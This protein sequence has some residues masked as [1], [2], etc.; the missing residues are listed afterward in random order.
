MPDP[1]TLAQIEA[2][3][4]KWDMRIEFRFWW[5]PLWSHLI[6]DAYAAQEVINECR[7]GSTMRWRYKARPIGTTQP[8]RKVEE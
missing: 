3:P 1:I 5:W 4:E 8:Y 2:E 7:R 6:V